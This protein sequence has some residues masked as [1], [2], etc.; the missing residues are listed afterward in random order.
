M[1][2]GYSAYEY[3]SR[4]TLRLR[5]RLSE[6]EVVSNIEYIYI[7]RIFTNL[8]LPNL[9]LTLLKK[10]FNYPLNCRDY[11]KMVNFLTT[12]ASCF[13]VE[14]VKQ[15]DYL[16]MQHTEYLLFLSLI[17]LNLT[18]HSLQCPACIARQLPPNP[19]S[20]HPWI[21]MTSSRSFESLT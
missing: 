8:A 19:L 18:V 5:S 21:F 3:R 16:I 15:L 2:R 13:W 11:L 6:C 20:G 10:L 1:V 17:E 4:C 12:E 14:Q 9:E 7:L